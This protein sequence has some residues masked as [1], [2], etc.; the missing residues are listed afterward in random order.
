MSSV[1]N[2]GKEK[3]AGGRHESICSSGSPEEFEALWQQT[4][5]GEA[6]KKKVKG[7][8][9]SPTSG[10]EKEVEA[11]AAALK[12][13]NMDDTA[14]EET[15]TKKSGEPSVAKENGEVSTEEV[16]DAGDTAK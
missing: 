6:Q 10:M 3:T 8:L 13:A 14:E 12:D 7:Q 2:Y 16:N 11:T 1:V 5:F 15:S 9:Q 4:P